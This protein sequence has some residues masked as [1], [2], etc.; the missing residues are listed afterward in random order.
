MGERSNQI[1]LPMLNAALDMVLEW[2]PERIQEYCANL[3]EPFE[4]AFRGA[5]FDLEDRSF[6]G[7]HLFGLRSR[8]GLDADATA[9]AL[10]RARVFVSV[11]GTAIR[12]A[13]QVY[14]GPSDME[15]LAAT[16]RSL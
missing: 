9:T 7:A 14:N 6:R 8:R 10:R 16:L 2:R 1:Q 4:D 11:R 12:V 5:G 15:A 13:P 3:L